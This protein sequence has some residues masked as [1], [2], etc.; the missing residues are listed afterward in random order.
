MC[1]ADTAEIFIFIRIINL[2]QIKNMQNRCNFH[3]TNYHQ[4]CSGTPRLQ[5]PHCEIAESIATC[6]E[7]G[8]TKWHKIFVI[9]RN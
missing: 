7:N 3:E 8:L 4:P 2:I 1:V 9:E 6:C 5:L